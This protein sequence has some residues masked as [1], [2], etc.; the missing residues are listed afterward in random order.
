MKRSKHN[1][2]HYKLLTCDM[3]Q[4]VPVCCYEVLPG[5]TLQQSGSMLLRVSPLLAPVMHP[6]TARI[7]YWFVPHRLVWEDFEKF[8]TGGEDGEGDGSVFPTIATPGGGFAQG[9]LADYLG[10]RPTLAALPV[11]AL[12]FR[13]YALIY[14]EMYRDQDLITA[15]TIDKTS[16]LDTTTNTALQNCAWEKDRFTSARPWPQKGPD[17]TLPLGSRAPVE[18]DPAGT[19]TADVIRNAV[20]KAVAPGLNLST[21]AVTGALINSGDTVSLQLDP[22]SL[23]ADLSAAT[24]VNVND[25]REAFAIQRYQEARAQFGSRYSE[26]L[27][28]LGVRPSDAR[29]QRPEY[30]GGGKQT[31]SFSEVLQTGVTTDGDDVEGV[32]N[33]RGHGIAAMRARPYRRFME[34]HGLVIGLMSVRPR[35]MYQQGLD[36]M[37]S[38]RTKE[39]FWQKE[40][41]H[42]GQEEIFSRELFADVDPAGAAVFGYG[43]R[44]SSYRHMQSGVAGDFRNT[45]DF[46][47]LAR[48]FSSAPTLNQ[49]F[50]ECEPSK[51]IH[52]VETEDVLWV[53]FSNK[54]HMRR[55]VGHGTGIG[56]IS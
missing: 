26:Y 19:N 22:N 15:L 13:S 46:W 7:H 44:Y 6:V 54:V 4:L 34:E 47:H 32:G 31:I 43:N 12:P 2:S 20:T 38:R 40:L 53:M 21:Q 52:Q 50:V 14:N 42:I 16:G 5:D 45:L 9:S 1:L 35:T 51:R 56:R 48:S 24:A 11:S 17:V 30:L 3:G 33:L 23:Y 8:I 18:W 37:W 36:R 39:D 28:F 55:M 25:V 29:L 49:D 27:R 10:I 41:E